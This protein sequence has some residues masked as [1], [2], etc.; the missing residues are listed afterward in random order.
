M[1]KEAWL[2]ESALPRLPE[3]L[4]DVVTAV[5]NLRTEDFSLLPLPEEGGRAGA[6]LILFAEGEQ[7][8]DVLILQRAAEMREHA[9]QPAFP[10]GAVDATDHDSVA[11]ALREAQEETGVEPAGVTV[12]GALPD[13]WLPPSGFVVTPVLGWW[14]T[15]T[16]IGVM[17]PGE[18]AAVH[19]VPIA[20]LL[21]PGNRVEVIH[22]SGYVGPGFETHDMLVW[23][24]TG[25]LLSQLF[26]A[27]GWTRPWL[28]ARQV[29]I[30]V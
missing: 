18:V 24:F 6:V 11:A 19:R 12:F 1:A 27:A 7:G 8:P 22:P 17:D 5:R 2:A 14:P 26:D 30:E 13:L 29:P 25:G 28:P 4:G 15:P 23:G 9:G 16:P 21:D 20:D 3:W 10:G